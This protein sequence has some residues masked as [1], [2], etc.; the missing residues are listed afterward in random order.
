M[1]CYYKSGQ[2]RTLLYLHLMIDNKTSFTKTRIAPTPSG[3]LH[4]GNVLSFALTA[5]IAQQTGAKILLRIDDLD[6]GRVHRAYVEDVF[7][8]LNFLEILWH[9]GPRNY[10]EYER[11]WSQTHRMPLYNEALK[12]LKD[13]HNVFACS[14]S[15]AQLAGKEA[16]PGTCRHANLDF[17]TKNISWRLHTTQDTELN[18]KTINN[19]IVSTALPNSMQHFVVR[20]KDG[21]PAYQLSSVID[22]VY[23]GVDL[24]VRGA[25]LWPS[26][27]AQHYLALKLDA[28]A[29]LN[30][31]FHHHPVLMES[32]GQKL[33]KSAG[34]TSIKYLREQGKKPAEIY[35]E[36]LK[37]AG[38]G[39]DYE[40]STW[41]Q[42]AES[43]V[44][45][46]QGG[47]ETN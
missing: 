44:L 18:V 43:I 42:L 25:D 12:K 23:F 24:I 47:A 28:Q 17:N 37:M 6:R 21:F 10:T 38:A 34:S 22:D 36:I 13:D 19:G 30:S 40:V 33:S 2:N 9:E 29:F 39:I 41:Q 1:C 14:C 20:K 11:E 4:L 27:L 32:G 35:Q 46:K 31:T 26:T 3:Y 7:D 8:T 16:Y 5:A 45:I 15:R